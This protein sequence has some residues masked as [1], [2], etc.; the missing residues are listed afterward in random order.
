MLYNEEGKD[1]DE[2]ICHRSIVAGL[3]LNMGA[4]IECSETYRVYRLNK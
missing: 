2:Q 4:S 1:D 3:L